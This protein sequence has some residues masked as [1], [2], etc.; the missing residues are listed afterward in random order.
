MWLD[1]VGAFLICF[2]PQVR[3][4]GSA[5]ERDS[6]SEIALMSNL[7]RHHVRLIRSGE[8]WLIE[9]LGP[10]FI[11]GRPIVK[12]SLLNDGN[13]LLLG[14]SVRLKFRLPSSL[15]GT[16]RIEFES[17]HRPNPSVDGVILLAETC[18]LGSGLDS[19]ITTRDGSDRVLLTRR[20]NGLWC[21]AS[22]GVSIDGEPGGT[23]VPCE[24]GKVYSG[25]NWR[26]RLESVTH[27]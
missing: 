9:P 7:S 2:D 21:Q 25:L 24:M 10:T 17:S 6:R 4:G 19:H 22:E 26:F 13:R 16:A 8:V 23:E 3:I 12:P 5:S 20:L 15:T 1:G 14:A 18:L 11:D 27:N